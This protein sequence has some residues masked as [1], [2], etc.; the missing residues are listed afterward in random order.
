MTNF[1]VCVKLIQ[2]HGLF[3]KTLYQTK[4]VIAS[5]LNTDQFFTRNDSFFPCFLNPNL[6]LT[7]TPLNMLV[8]LRH[9][10]CEL[11]IYVAHLSFCQRPVP[12]AGTKNLCAWGLIPDLD[13]CFSVFIKPI[14]S[15]IR[16]LYKHPIFTSI[17]V[18]VFLLRKE[19]LSNNRV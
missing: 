14:E 2:R 10:N 4:T 16:A 19:N 8:N 13:A 1:L 12:G 17:F 15:A 7:M 9:L 5:Q 3:L 18:I 6:S 11:T